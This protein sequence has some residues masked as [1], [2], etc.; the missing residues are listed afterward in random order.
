MLNDWKMIER[1]TPVNLLKIR[2]L[3]VPVLTLA[4]LCGGARTALA[5]GE[6]VEVPRITKEKLLSLIG[7][8]DLV[9][10]DVRE[11]S[12][13]KESKWKIKGAIRENPEDDVITWAD[14]I[15]KDKTLVLYCS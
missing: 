6:N 3:I 2:P 11:A 10:L 12:H 14:K 15:P 7:S 8:P 5:M 13:W 4:L 1:R 9:I